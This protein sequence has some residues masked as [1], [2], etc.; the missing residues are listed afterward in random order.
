MA[1]STTASQKVGH[2]LAAF[3]RI[4]LTASNLAR[5]PPILGNDK[6]ADGGSIYSATSDSYIEEEPTVGQWIAGFKPTGKGAAG[7]TLSL[8]PFVTWIGRYN[9]KWL[10][11]DL[12]AGITVGCV[13]IPQGSEYILSPNVGKRKEKENSYTPE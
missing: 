1:E 12:V 7:F 9:L 6:A 3:L 2:A 4:D 5:N 10:Y 8:F 11:G 13:V